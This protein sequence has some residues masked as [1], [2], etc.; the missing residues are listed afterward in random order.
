[1]LEM[2]QNRL[3]GCENSAGN[4]AVQAHYNFIRPAVSKLASTPN[5]F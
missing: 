4:R 2:L 5:I 3:S 1:M